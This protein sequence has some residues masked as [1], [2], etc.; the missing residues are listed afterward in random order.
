[1]GAAIPKQYLSLLGRPVLAH[2]LLRLCGHARIEGVWVGTAADD[3]HWD[4]LAAG[5]RQPKVLGTFRGGETRA[6][7]VL[8]GLRT[9]AARAQPD[10]WVM[11]HDAVRPCVRLSDID[12]L[13][14]VA[15]DHPDGGLLGVPVSDT[16]KRVDREEKIIE[17]VPRTD[18]WR[19]LTPQLFPIAKLERALRRAIADGSD[20]TDEASAIEFDG[21]RPIVV[22]GHPD[23]VKITM[24]DDLALAELLLQQ[25]GR[26]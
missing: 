26:A 14:A 4:A 23:N 12:K 3:A 22:L 17:T 18:L 20:V 7:T 10:D 21:G 19:A 25:Q 24:P 16:V 2:T 9:L 6:H 8:N 15:M 11:V 5:L 1:M 13:I